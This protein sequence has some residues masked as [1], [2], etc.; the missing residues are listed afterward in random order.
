M[1]IA[2]IDKHPILRKGLSIFLE[3]QFPDATIIEAESFSSYQVLHAEKLPD[4]MILGLEEESV[5]LEAA[6]IKTLKESLPE[7]LLIIYDGESRY[8]MAIS[9]LAAGASAY[10]LKKDELEELSKCIATVLDGKRYVDDQMLSILLSQSQDVINKER[11]LSTLSRGEYQVA[12]FLSQ[13]MQTSEIANLQ[14]DKVATINKQ[15][16]TIFKKLNITNTIELQD[17]LFS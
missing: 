8:N 14:R 13:G 4:L 16:S 15:R 17:I 3:C 2:S 5:P 10:L 7:T 12:K 1:I 11:S 9:C 6:T